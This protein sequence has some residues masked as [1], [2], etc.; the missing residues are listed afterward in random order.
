MTDATRGSGSAET[1]GQVVVRYWAA[2]RAAAGVERDTLEV[3]GPVNLDSVLEQL[4]TLHGD[5]PRFTDVLGVCSV[6]VD[7]RPVGKRG[8]AE[9]VVRP[10]ETVELLPPFAGGSGEA[11]PGMSGSWRPT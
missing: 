5:R 11:T 3:S 10:G 9:V 7:D 2:I 4:R 1:R 6:L 8:H